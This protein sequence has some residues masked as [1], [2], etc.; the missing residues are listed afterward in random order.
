MLSY[1]MAT[2]SA[3]Q[4]K[5]PSLKCLQEAQVDEGERSVEPKPIADGW[6][7]GSASVKNYVILAAP[8]HKENLQDDIDFRSL[9]QG[10]TMDKQEKSSP[11]Y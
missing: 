11:A 8:E 3:C 4:P 1:L 6:P 10:F 9:N 5:A 7:M 2:D